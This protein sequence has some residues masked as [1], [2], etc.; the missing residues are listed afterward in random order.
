MPLPN[1]IVSALEVVKSAQ[2]IIHKQTAIISNALDDVLL[3]EGGFDHISLEEL[4]EIISLLPDG[5]FYQFYLK[6]EWRNRNN[7]S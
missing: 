6:K 3:Q 4:K 5:C 1:N 7:K 2:E